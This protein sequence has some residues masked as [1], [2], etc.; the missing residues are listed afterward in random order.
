ML[1]YTK[2]LFHMYEIQF[3]WSEPFARLLSRPVRAFNGSSINQ[4]IG[5]TSP[6]RPGILKKDKQSC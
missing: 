1:L 5:E 3:L 6:Q 2:N 4:E